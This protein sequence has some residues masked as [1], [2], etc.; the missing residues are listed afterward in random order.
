ML[1]R[2]AR[3]SVHWMAAVLGS[4]SRGMNGTFT[5]CTPFTCIG[6]LFMVD[7]TTRLTTLTRLGFAARGLLYIV[8]AMLVLTTGRAEDPAGALR[9]LAREV[10]RCWYF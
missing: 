6:R 5:L 8:I 3:R 4:L 1:F 9:I 2:L 7:A 10:A